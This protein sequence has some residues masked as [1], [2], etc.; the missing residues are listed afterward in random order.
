MKDLSNLSAAEPNPILDANSPRWLM[1]PDDEQK[2]RFNVLVAGCGCSKVCNA[3]AD[4]S[5]DQLKLI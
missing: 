5:D 3:L 1:A 4:L 2:E